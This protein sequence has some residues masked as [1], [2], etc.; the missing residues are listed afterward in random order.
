MLCKN[1][2]CVWKMPFGLEF[3]QSLSLLNLFIE[4]IGMFDPKHSCRRL[5]IVSC[6]FVYNFI[7]FSLRW[8]ND[9][10]SS[11]RSDSLR[12][13][14]IYRSTH[15]MCDCHWFVVIM[16]SALK[17]ESKKKKSNG[18]NRSAIC[19]LNR[20]KNSKFCAPY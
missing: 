17:A 20:G 13:L 9:S 7:R 14:S 6:H 4:T 10:S 12:A 19:R 2:L 3:F 8:F 1:W 5:A 11:S 16:W 15:A 18:S